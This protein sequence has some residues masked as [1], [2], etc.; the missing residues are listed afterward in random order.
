MD[1]EYRSKGDIEARTEA[2]ELGL[3]CMC[4]ASS[5]PRELQQLLASLCFVGRE[6]VRDN[7]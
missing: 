7:G 2:W 1:G 6:A 5:L 3:L 4:A